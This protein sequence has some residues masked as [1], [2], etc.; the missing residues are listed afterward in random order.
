VVCSKTIF[1]G[2]PFIRP[3]YPLAKKGGEGKGG[4]GRNGG[5]KKEQYLH[6]NLPPRYPLGVPTSIREEKG[7][8]GKRE[9]KRVR[10]D[11]YLGPRLE[12][13]PPGKEKKGGKRGGK[14]GGK[15]SF[16]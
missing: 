15:S 11:T 6:H 13:S 4:G 5:E 16:L 12:L 7:R 3:L 9:G 2:L 8:K 10:S 14:N 1:S